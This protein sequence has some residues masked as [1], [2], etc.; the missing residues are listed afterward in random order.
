VLVGR[1][2][3]PARP[4]DA[5]LVQDHGEVRWHRCLR[6]DTWLPLPLPESPSRS[7]PPDRAQIV[8]PARGKALHDRIVLRLIAIDRVIHFIVL[9]LIGLGVLLFASHRASLHDAYYR[10][11]TALQG[12]VAG[13]PVQTSGHVGILRDFDRLFSLRSGTLHEVGAALLGYGILEGIEAIGLWLAKRWAEYLTFIATTILLPLEIYEIIHEGTVL[14]VI[15]FLINLAVV[16]WLLWRKRLFGL[17]GGGDAEAAERAR[18]VSWEEIE[19]RTLATPAPNPVSAREV[20][21]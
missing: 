4:Q 21:A 8:V 19:R 16:V 17:N 12:G 6:C 2:A 9:V 7:H 20:T 11:L 10:I 15:G 3:G 1:D 13:G 14:K 18:D 5:I